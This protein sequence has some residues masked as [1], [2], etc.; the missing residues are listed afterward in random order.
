MRHARPLGDRPQLR[1]RRQGAAPVRRGAVAHRRRATSARYP[2]AGLPNAFGEYDETAGETARP[3]RASSRR[4][5]FVNIVGGCC[6]T[7]PE[8]IAR[9]RRGG[10]RAAAAR[11]ADAAEPRCRLARP[12]AAEH[13]ADDSLFVNVGE[14]TNVTGSAKFRQ[15]DRGGRLRRRARR[16]APAGRERRADHRRQH[17][18]GHARFGSARWRA[19]STCSPPSRTSRACR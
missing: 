17:G 11:R 5:G 15:P 13:R 9:D 8:H 7:T 6:G 10:R 16:R 14:R 2:N 3:D 1:A 18:R 4:S 19:S 12:R